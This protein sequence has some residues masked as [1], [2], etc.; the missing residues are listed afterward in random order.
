MKR[1]RFTEEQ[2]I[3]VL[4]RPKPGPRSRPCAVKWGTTED[5]YREGE[6]IYGKDGST[7]ILENSSSFPLSH[8]PDDN[9]LSLRECS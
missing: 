8:R 1:K 5:V 3:E 6:A 7:G 9:K 2:I 4:N